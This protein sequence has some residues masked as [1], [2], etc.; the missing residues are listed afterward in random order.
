MPELVRLSRQDDIAVITI[1]NPPVNALGPGVP[2]GLQNA[3]QQV[4]AD[5]RVKAIVLIGAG[6]TFIAGADIREFG[7]IVSGEKP[8]LTLLPY[9]RSIED[10]PKPV[11]TAIHGQALGGGLETA[12][13]AHYRVIA[14]TAQVGQPEVKLGL[15]PGAGGTQRLPRLAGVIKALEMCAAGEPVKA[16]DAVAV[17]IAD[18]IVEGDLLQG[19]IA[20]AREIAGKPFPKTRELQEKLRGAAPMFFDIARDQARKRGRGMRAPLAA[21]DAVE[22]A[23]R[24]H[25]DEG[26][27]REA[28]LF[29]ECL[30]STQSKALIHAFFGERAVSKIPAFRRTPRLTIFAARP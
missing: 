20:F 4:A 11:V 3:I 15:I 14:P 10:S 5:D 23:T 2:E 16:A 21:I 30:F 28:E 29:D 13:S 22:A 7:K 26:C 6:S 27:R 12:M 1:D 25:F 8:R 24:L 9:L 19:A 18:R 17:G